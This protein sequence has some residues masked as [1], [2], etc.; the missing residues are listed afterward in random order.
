MRSWFATPAIKLPIG[1]RLRRELYGFT[2]AEALGRVT[3]EILQTQFP[4]NLEKINEQ[5][6]RDGRWNGELV[7]MRKDGTKVIVMSRWVLDREANG[8]ARCILETNNDITQ[9][10]Q[11]EK[12][13]RESEERFRAIVETTPECVK[14]ISADGTLLHMNRP[15][16]EMVGARS[17]DEV[18][19]KSVYDL[20]APEDRNRFKA[21]NERICR[22][23]QGS[24]QF[25]IIGL[26]GKRRHMETHAAALRNPDE[27]IV[28]L[29]CYGRHFRTE[30]GGGIAAAERRAVPRTRERQF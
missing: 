4:Q 30:A 9:P 27:R 7:H 20:I 11:T 12:A 28:H 1:T 6:H 17:A 10:K 29:G 16:L 22:G 18:I 24:L 15:G 3:H 25:D 2:R 5:L 14:L 21:F 13:L 19:G 23:E 8:N 26:E